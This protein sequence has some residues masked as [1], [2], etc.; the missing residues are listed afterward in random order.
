M[1]NRTLRIICDSYF[2]QEWAVFF[3]RNFNIEVPVPLGYLSSAQGRKLLPQAKKPPEEAS[4]TLFDYPSPGAVWQNSVFCICKTDAVEIC[5]VEGPNGMQR[6]DNRPFLW[7]SNEATRIAVFS[8][9]DYRATFSI[10][11]FRPGPS[12]PDDTKRTLIVRDG[13]GT[14]RFD[15]TGSLF[16]DLILH[17]GANSVQVSCEE[18]PTVM[19]LPNGDPRTLL[20]GIF[21]FHVKPAN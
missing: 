2:N 14:R 7:L 16:V 1:A 11:S 18:H 19:H 17:S 5:G 10:S 8:K 3:L 6:M 12:R 4:Y 21:D 15:A 9:G 13:R 20:L